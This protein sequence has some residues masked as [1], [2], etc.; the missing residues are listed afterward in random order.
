MYYRAIGFRPKDEKWKKMKAAWDACM[1]AGV[2]PPDDIYRFFDGEPPDLQGIKVDLGDHVC[3][4]K[5]SA[6]MTDGFEIDIFKLPENITLL[7]FTATA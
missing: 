6:D 5:Y 4:T 1:D 2:D 7:R 3:C